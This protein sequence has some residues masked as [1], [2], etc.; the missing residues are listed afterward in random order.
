MAER[1]ANEIGYAVSSVERIRSQNPFTLWIDLCGGRSFTFQVALVAWTVFC[2]IV[3]M[4]MLLASAPPPNDPLMI[5]PEERQ[6]AAGA[7]VLTGLCC[8]LGTWALI[9]IPLAFAI[10]AT[11]R[12]RH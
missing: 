5:L 4:G 8:P 6:A 12:S 3:G 1:R 2:V 11:W 10:V 9:A 7:F